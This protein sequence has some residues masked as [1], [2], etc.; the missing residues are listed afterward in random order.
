MLE[1]MLTIAILFS[2]ASAVVAFW[3]NPDIR[4][5]GPEGPLMDGLQTLGCDYRQT[6]R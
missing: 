6:A 1:Q 2:A 5:A 4:L 3:H